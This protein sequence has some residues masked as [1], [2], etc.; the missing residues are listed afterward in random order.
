MTPIS[1]SK[2]E[3]VP[4]APEIER[5]ERERVVQCAVKWI[6]TP[7]A[8][9]GRVRGGGVDCAT[10]LAEVYCAAGLI[11]RIAL[12]QYSPQWHMHRHEEKLIAILQA[13]AV[14]TTRAPQTGDV[15]AWK[16]FNLHCHG[17]IVTKWPRLIHAHMQTS[18]VEHEDITSAVWLSHVSERTADRG[19]PR[20]FR[21]FTFWP[22]A[23]S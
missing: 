19:K 14:E 1:F 3:R 4:V 18:R 12:P 9:E 21:V 15:I 10:L 2:I 7:Y 22:E 8:H 13:L 6:G 16:F 17:S 5:R 20:S 23:S 11:P